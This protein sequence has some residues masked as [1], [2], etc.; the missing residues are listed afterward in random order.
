VRGERDRRREQGASGSGGRRQEVAADFG[1]GD[2]PPEL[3][4]DEVELDD[5]PLD[6]LDD[7]DVLLEDAAVSTLFAAARE[8]VR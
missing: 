4:A 7:E 3:L 8:S 1:A 5:E 6:E 2:E